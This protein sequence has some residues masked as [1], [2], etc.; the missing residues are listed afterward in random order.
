MGWAST[1]VLCVC[2]CVCASCGARA[3]KNSCTISSV[4]HSFLPVLLR[5]YT[6]LF[7]LLTSLVGM[8]C[9]C[10]ARK[11]WRHGRREIMMAMMM[12]QG[13]TTTT[14]TTTSKTIW[15]RKEGDDD[16]DREGEGSEQDSRKEII[17]TATERKRK[18]KRRKTNKQVPGMRKRLDT[19]QEKK[20]E[21]ERMH[22]VALPLSSLAIF[23]LSFA[24]P[25]QTYYIEHLFI[26]PI[27]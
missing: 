2:V 26:H 8:P 11:E 25:K 18:R 19:K 27:L 21:R 3:T 14:A 7:M 4:H 23:S 10:V 13:S 1:C 5:V 20:Q 6:R 24:E 17:M 12:V 15:R 9:E 22:V 16:D